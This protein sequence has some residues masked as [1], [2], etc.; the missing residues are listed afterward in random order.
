MN[1]LLTARYGWSAPI[2]QWLRNLRRGDVVTI[3]CAFGGIL[4]GMI[5]GS[6]GPAM[7]ISV[8]LA[9]TALWAFWDNGGLDDFL[10]EIGEL[11]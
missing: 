7:A 6:A 2:I 8:L 5:L 3:A 10:P 9:G 11:F 1:A 4:T